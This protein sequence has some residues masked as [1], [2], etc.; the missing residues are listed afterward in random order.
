M[1]NVR[2]ELLPFPSRP[3]N[4]HEPYNKKHASLRS[5][6]ERIFGVIQERFKIIV[7][8]RD[9][10]LKTQ[11]RVFPALAVVHNFIRL[12]DPNDNVHPD[13]LAAWIDEA[14]QEAAE[15]DLSSTTNTTRAE[16][17]RGEDM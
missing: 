11:A 2:P 16:K 14:A 7:S 12:H 1:L 9:Y 3:R 5:V 13:D 6:V 10:D 17:K 4:A 8:G 15:D